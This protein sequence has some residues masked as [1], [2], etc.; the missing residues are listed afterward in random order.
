MLFADHSRWPG[1]VQERA[2]TTDSSS[3]S[4]GWLHPKA[5]IQASGL[6]MHFY[7]QVRTGTSAPCIPKASLQTDA[8]FSSHSTLASM[9]YRRF[10]Q[11]R[12]HSL[13]HHFFLVGKAGQEV[14]LAIFPPTAQACLRLE[15]SPFQQSQAVASAP[16]WPPCS[17]PFTKGASKT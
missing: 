11:Q 13:N 1:H 5:Y 14:P 3:V 9:I 2:V 15:K 10:A 8:R 12:A 17:Q 16:C 6:M 7:G 4:W